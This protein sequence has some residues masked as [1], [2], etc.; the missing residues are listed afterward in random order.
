MTGAV[1]D[2]LGEVRTEQAINVALN[3]QPGNAAAV[4]VKRVI[5]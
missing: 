1:V 3:I 2:P 5:S 4:P